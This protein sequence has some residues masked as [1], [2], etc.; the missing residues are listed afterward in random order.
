MKIGKIGIDF[1]S[2]LSKFNLHIM[3]LWLRTMCLTLEMLLDT[4][5]PSFLSKCLPIYQKFNVARCVCE[6]FRLEC[7]LRNTLHNIQRRTHTMIWM[8]NKLFKTNSIKKGSQ[9]IHIHVQKLVSKL[10][11]YYNAQN[12]MCQHNWHIYLVRFDTLRLL[13]TCL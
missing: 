6:I 10:I 9:I 12:D 1:I 11:N 3:C 13:C 8:A 4:H 5:N 7:R 2:V